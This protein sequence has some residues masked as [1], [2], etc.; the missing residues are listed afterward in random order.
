MVERGRAFPHETEVAFDRTTGRY[1]V[2]FREKPEAKEER[3][4]GT[5]EMPADLYNGMGSTLARHLN[6]GRATG[7]ILVFTPKPR[8]LAM[9]LSPAGEDTFRIA[10]VARAATRYLMKLEAHRERWASSPR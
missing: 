10:G 2:R 4:E 6:G 3:Q 1:R 5:V 7:H 9:E 8:L